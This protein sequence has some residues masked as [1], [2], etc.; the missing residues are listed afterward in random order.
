MAWRLGVLTFELVVRISG[1]K[2]CLR[3]CIVAKKNQWS[4]DFEE[5]R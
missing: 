1:T 5:P 4:I 3:H 2:N